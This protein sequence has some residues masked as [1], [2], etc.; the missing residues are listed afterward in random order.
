VDDD[1]DPQLAF[2]RAAGVLLGQ[3]QAESRDHASQ[4]HLGSVAHRMDEREEAVA[5]VGEPV[6]W[7]GWIPAARSAASNSACIV[8][9]SS[10]LTSSGRLVERSTSR[11][12][13]VR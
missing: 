4:Q 11:A 9:R 1:T 2:R 12:T 3:Q 5:P 10:A 13:M 6:P 8:W 7:R